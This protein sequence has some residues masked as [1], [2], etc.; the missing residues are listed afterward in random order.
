MSTE[1]PILPKKFIPPKKRKRKEKE[2]DHT[3]AKITTGFLHKTNM[4]LYQLQAHGNHSHHYIFPDP[5]DVLQLINL[6]RAPIATVLLSDLQEYKACERKWLL[7]HGH[8]D[9]KSRTKCL[10]N[11]ELEDML[12]IEKKKAV[13]IEALHA[14]LMLNNNNFPTSYP[15]YRPDFKHI[16]SRKVS[17]AM[18]RKVMLDEGMERWVKAWD[19]HFREDS[20]VYLSGKYKNSEA[21]YK[22]TLD[23]VAPGKVMFCYLMD[24]IPENYEELSRN[25]IKA[26][27]AY[28]HITKANE[29][30]YA[31]ASQETKDR[32]KDQ[33]KNLEFTFLYFEVDYI[34][35]RS[36]ITIRKMESTVL[37]LK[38]EG[39]VAENYKR[40]FAEASL[41]A[42]EIINIKS[43]EDTTKLKKEECKNL[44]CEWA[45]SCW[46]GMSA[47]R[48]RPMV[49]KDSRNKS[50]KYLEDRHFRE[51][52]YENAILDPITPEVI[53]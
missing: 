40:V 36:C 34:G 32:H 8:Y 25:N 42:T 41:K 6:D 35:V 24:K 16:R 4:G 31:S 45:L 22:I 37:H 20:L 38:V 18:T 52:L 12:L 46:V 19:N 50:L 7:E 49:F 51:K 10:D 30:F 48:L 29:D 5:T 23:L 27:I 39:E 2:V 17:V 26:S 44:K 9:L 53:Y 15:T 33:H 3:K 43:S 28:D 47:K 1:D 13:F 21:A 11:L 14:F